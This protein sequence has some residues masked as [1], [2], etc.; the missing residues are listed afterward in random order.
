VKGKILG[1]IMITTSTIIVAL[2]TLNIIQFGDLRFVI[3][4]PV[5]IYVIIKYLSYVREEVKRES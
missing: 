5:G 1:W 2:A 4:I 3:G